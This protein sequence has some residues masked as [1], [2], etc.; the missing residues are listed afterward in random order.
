MDLIE[1]VRK[2]APGKLGMTVKEIC[3]AAGLPKT[4]YQLGIVRASLSDALEA[5]KIRTLREP[6]KTLAGFVQT[7]TTYA[8]AETSHE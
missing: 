1:I 4:P 3:A 2:P 7:V 8:S 6:R 5:G